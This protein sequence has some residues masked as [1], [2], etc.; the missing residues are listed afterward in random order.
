MTLI[1]GGAPRSAGEEA[2]EGA[3]EMLSLLWWG[4][5][6]G[7]PG[8]ALVGLTLCTR[9][10]APSTLGPLLAAPSIDPATAPR[11]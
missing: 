1:L 4:G 5:A 8:D 3:G 9:P 7:P 2:V 6:Q 10:G 11:P